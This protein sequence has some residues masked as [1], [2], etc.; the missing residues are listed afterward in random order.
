MIINSP[1]YASSL[2]ERLP[3][4]DYLKKKK[5]QE[6]FYIKAKLNSQLAEQLKYLSRKP[7]P[8]TTSIVEV[9][10]KEDPRRVCSSL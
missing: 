8:R 6:A 7:H 1:G 3:N 10:T 4:R 5:S 2:K 9:P